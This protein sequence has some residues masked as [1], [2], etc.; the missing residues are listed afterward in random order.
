MSLLLL[1]GVHTLATAT[2]SGALVDPTNTP[3]ANAQLTA[4][5]D[6]VRGQTPLRVGPVAL[7]RPQSSTVTSAADGTFAFAQI[8]A[9]TTVPSGI[10]TWVRGPEGMAGR[11]TVSGSGNLA[12]LAWGALSGTAAATCVVSGQIVAADG[13]AASGEV[14]TFALDAP[15][16]ML[17]VTTD[18]S[19]VVPRTVSVTAAADG[20][21]TV[22]LLRQ[23][24]LVPSGLMVTVHGPSLMYGRIAVPNQAGANLFD[25]L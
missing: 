6:V 2:V 7:I 16:G 5:T 23:A 12:E 24:S 11:V 9:G 21:F 1:F 25:L 22:T 4:V 18:R 10:A 13:P 3:V 8:P 17:I 14:L 19:V 20:T 15:P